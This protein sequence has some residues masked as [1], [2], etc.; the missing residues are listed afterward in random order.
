MLVLVLNA[1][2]SSIKYQIIDT[3][4][5]KTLVKKMIDA[6]MT[7][8]DYKKAFAT[9]TNECK[10]YHIEAV[11]HRIVHGGNAYTKPTI[12]TKKVITEIKKL[13]HL[14]PLHNPYN[15]KGIQEAQKMFPKIPHIA[16]FDTGFYATLPEKA[17]RY[18]IPSEWY[19]KFAVKKYG[20]HGTS[21]EYVIQKA[22]SEMKRKGS[23]KKTEFKI[24]SCHLGNGCSVTASINGKAVE[25]SMGFTPLQ[26]VTMGTRSGDIDPAVIPYLAEKLHCTAEEVVTKLN[27]Q[28]GLKAISELSSDMRVIHEEALKGNKKCQQAMEIFC[29]SIAKYIG[30]FAGIM[31]GV[32]AIIFTAGIGENAD[33]IRQ[34]ICSYFKN[35]FKKTKILVVPTNE[36]LAIALKT[37][38]IL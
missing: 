18:S 26:G 13:S 33:Y 28:S 29:Y 11:G 3:K 24:I 8:K 9:M 32:D 6:I 16:V 38:K 15:L 27:K 10:K 22:L 37:E 20:F 12:V 23:K 14:A 1:G 19:T 21:H 30:A 17:W 31:D 34:K 7:P 5:Q 2:S 25:T 36:E 4:T 35:T